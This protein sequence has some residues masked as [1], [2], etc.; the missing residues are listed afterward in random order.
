MNENLQ[1]LVWLSNELGKPE[2]NFAL[3]GE[4]NTSCCKNTE[5]FFVKSSG[6]SLAV[7][8]PE[9]FVEVSFKKIL[10]LLDKKNPGTEIIEKTYNESRVKKN[11]TLRPS[12][13]TLFHAVCLSYD[14]I[15][16]V[17]H[18]HPVSI[19]K[20][21]CSGN[22]PAIL[23]GRMYP[24]EV[25]VLGI[26]SI[27]IPYVDPGVTLAKYIKKEIDGYIKK[28]EELPKA[29]YMQNHG[30]IAL[31]S[32]AKEVLNITLTADKAAVIRLGALQAGG[33]ISLLDTKDVLGILNRP[34][35][36]YRKEKLIGE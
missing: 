6:S 24:D 20:L 13:E 32:T 17:G 1:K 23:R 27:F 28:Y 3:L 12:V 26:D 18:T 8:K 15:N 33:G 35:E 2:N 29:V 4:G 21:T 9:Q 10:T 36:K 25:V 14:S 22:Y 5:S 34:D 7:M 19:N 30:F 11:E 31:G 16:F